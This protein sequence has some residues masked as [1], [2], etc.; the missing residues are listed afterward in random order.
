M[1]KVHYHFDHVGSY[2]R[3]Q[4]LKEAREKFANGEISQEELLKVQD[5]LVKEL[6]HHEVENGLQVVSDG[7]FGRSWWHLDFLWNL[8]GFEAAYSASGM[9]LPRRLYM[10]FFTARRMFS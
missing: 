6:V 1:S 10:V 9:G 7:E 3:P 8:T 4:A 5:E 2:L